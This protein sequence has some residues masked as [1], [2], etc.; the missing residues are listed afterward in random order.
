MNQ[1]CLY[2]IVLVLSLP[3]LV[4]AASPS[5]ELLK[6]GAQLYDNWFALAGEQPTETH[7]IYPEVGQKQGAVTWRC[8]ECHGWDYLG[9]QGRY[10]EGPHY[11]GIKGVRGVR[12]WSQEGLKKLLGPKGRHDFTAQL[13]RDDIVA[14]TLFLRTGLV[15]ARKAIDGEGLARGSSEL[16]KPLYE[17]QCAACHG[18]EGQKLELKPEKEGVQG[19][20]WLARDNPQETLHKILWGQPG[21]AMPSMRVDAG[22]SF[23]QVVD[24]LTYSQQLP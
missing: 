23:E 10:A 1:I 15:D 4:A 8:Q 24:L 20:G 16:G 6:R 11:T 14:L 12:N 19:V 13:S 5:P 2:M 17:A 21:S 7:S 22:L 18:A 9:N 3:T